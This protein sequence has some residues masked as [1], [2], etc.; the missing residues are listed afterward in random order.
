MVGFA[1]MKNKIPY[2]PYCYFNT[3]D[4]MCPYWELRENGKAEC[5]YL[6]IDDEELS[7]K[8]KCCFVNLDYEYD[9]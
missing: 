1:I 7:F 6:M 5:K 4:K 9:E 2:G 8:L 3:P